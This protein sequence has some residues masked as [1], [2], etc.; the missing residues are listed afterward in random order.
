MKKKTPPRVIRF[1]FFQATTHLVSHIK[2]EAD[3]HPDNRDRL[4]GAARSVAQATTKMIE[5]AKDCQSRPQ[6]AESQMALRTATEDLQK[7][8]TD[9]SADQLDRRAIQ[10]LEQAARVTASNATQTIGA[11]NAAREYITTTSHTQQ[12]EL[13]YQC[14]ETAEFVPRLIS[15]IKQSQNASQASEKIMA[16]SELIRQCGE[17][18]QPCTRLVD[19][20]QTTVPVVS[21][22]SSALRLTT[23]SQQLSEGLAELRTA[24]TRAQ[25]VNVSMNLDYAVEVR[26]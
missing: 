3:S 9:A 17:V 8:T 26:C 6:A 4:L 19:V 25:E 20:V 21:D 5:A 1:D 11:A 18:L 22:Q 24:L 12:E 16:Q 14:T 13:F 10:R 23:T 2:G 15:S 7:A